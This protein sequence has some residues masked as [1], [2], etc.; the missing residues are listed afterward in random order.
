MLKLVRQINLFPKITKNVLED[1]L[2]QSTLVNGKHFLEKVDLKS[3]DGGKIDFQS[4]KKK[5]KNLSIYGLFFR[6]Y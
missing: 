4:L 2:F 5:V 1:R 3:S 6:Q